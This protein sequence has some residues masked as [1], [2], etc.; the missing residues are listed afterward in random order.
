[1]E[2]GISYRTHT[3]SSLHSKNQKQYDC[4]TWLDHAK[5]QPY[6]FES[7]PRG[8]V[9]QRKPGSQKSLVPH[10]FFFTFFPLSHHPNTPLS[11]SPSFFSSIEASSPSFLSKADLGGE[12]PS[13]MAYS[14]VDGA[15]SHLFSFVFR[16]ISMVENNH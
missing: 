3:L 7:H 4:S 2:A 16:C 1:M 12:A 14:L 10:V 5:R 8:T 13:S 6:F 15:S 11:F 9:P